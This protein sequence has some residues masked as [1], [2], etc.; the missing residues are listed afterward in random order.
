M[1][2]K[3]IVDNSG[4]PTGVIIPIGEWEEI[5]KKHKDLHD[6]EIH[7]SVK[8]KLPMSAFKGT[9]SKE[10]GAALQ[11]LVEQSRNEWGQ[12]S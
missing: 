3:Y 9:I 2:L 7:S 8:R 4:K 10:T 12:D 11:K 6:L 1:P 5:I